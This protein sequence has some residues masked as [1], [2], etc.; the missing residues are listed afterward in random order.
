[1]ARPLGV[2]ATGTYVVTGGLGA[3]G[4]LIARWLV[5]RGARHLVLMTRRALDESQ[6]PALDRLRAT[7]AELHVAR[8][9]VSQPEAVQ[10]ALRELDRAGWPAVCGVVHAAGVLEDGL[11]AQQT[12]E[13][14]QRV[15]APKVRGALSLHQATLDSPL[16]F[17][18]LVSSAAALFGSPGQG[19]YSAANAFLDAFAHWRQGQ[20]LV[21][22]SINLGALSGGG[23]ATDVY[24]RNR[25]RLSL[26]GFEM[27]EPDRAV[28]AIEQVLRSEQAQLGVLA[29]D[30]PRV[31]E[32]VR[33]DPRA[34][35]LSDFPG[36]D[37][38][39]E[40][41][42]PASDQLISELRGLARDEAEAR[43][44]RLV[45]HEV[46]RIAGVGSELDPTQG[47][48]DMG[49]DSL[50]IL[51]LKNRLQLVLGASLPATYAFNY[52]N[53][54]TLVEHLTERML[55]RTVVA[56]RPAQA[57]EAAEAVL[58][59]VECMSEAEL[60]RLIDG[61]LDSLGGA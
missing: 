21:A 14:F 25:T 32:R 30:R 58:S 49:M 8:V 38:G 16:A 24:E 52:P 60:E 22:T 1:P 23:M 28:E 15:F 44:R 26:S 37:A 55:G 57:R 18:L 46:G 13:R 10:H 47:F 39:A 17:F 7:G 36:R 9:D 5:E 41:K 33:A 20:G 29:F 6:A 61:E 48:F 35:L 2:T 45:E 34:S 54:E 50:M 27:I 42:R 53:V 31:V 40:T 4:L 56:K 43:L 19:A 3:L 11:L 59:Q 51:D 12:P